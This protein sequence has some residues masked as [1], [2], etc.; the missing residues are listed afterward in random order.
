MSGHGRAGVAGAAVKKAVLALV[1][2]LVLAP[3][4][5]LLATQAAELIWRWYLAPQYG[6]GPTTRAWFGM[7]ALAS[8][9]LVGIAHLVINHGNAKPVTVVTTLQTVAM[10]QAAA[11][12]V[13]LSAWWPRLLGWI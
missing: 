5:S 10:T 4:S 8:L 1:V 3:I 9:A 2:A 6:A 7:S 11:W 13:V 12:L